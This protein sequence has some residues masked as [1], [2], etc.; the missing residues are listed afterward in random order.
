MS[1]ARLHAGLADVSTPDWHFAPELLRLLRE[2]PGT[3][4]LYALACRHYARSLL[5]IHGTFM[6]LE[7]VVPYGHL[8]AAP[9][10]PLPELMSRLG[11]NLQPLLSALRLPGEWLEN[12]DHLLP[13][14]TVGEL[15]AS[16]ADQVKCEHLGLL[17]GNRSSVAQIGAVGQIMLLMPTVGKALEVL[18]R[19]LDLHDRAAVV[20]LRRQGGQ[21]ALGYS[22]FEGSFL[23]GQYIHD[24]AITIGL[25]IM[26]AL[27]GPVWK[28]QQMTFAHRRPSNP[29][30]YESFFGS[31]CQFDSL[32]TE[33]L[34]PA[35]QLDA[36]LYASCPPS[37]EHGNERITAPREWAERVRSATYMQLLSGNCSQ[38]L[39][40]HG[41]GVS[42]R[43]LNRRLAAEG[44]SYVEHLDRARFAISRMLL[45][46]TDMSIKAVSQLLNYSDA[47]SFNRAFRRW[48]GHTPLGW[49]QAH[50]ARS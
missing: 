11:G 50:Q 48:T 5:F 25:N 3:R 9:L 40:A 19:R 18:Q 31:P 20:T 38:Q 23:G 39:I 43:T 2:A 33:M 12:P 47:A 30:A 37:S 42:V 27:C 41:L 35:E 15:L 8:R 46:E 16:A 49:R 32:C 44:A 29:G 14:L 28:P 6:A 34:F 24:T 10:H 13:I 22:L 4:L 17:L 36:P 26:R 1:R 21:A 45:K 7:L